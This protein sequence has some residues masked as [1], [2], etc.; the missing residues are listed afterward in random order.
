MRGAVSSLINLA[1]LGTCRNVLILQCVVR[2][3]RIGGQRRV[4]VTFLYPFAIP[5]TVKS[6]SL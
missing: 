4:F 5:K 2:A 1:V 6:I 3:S